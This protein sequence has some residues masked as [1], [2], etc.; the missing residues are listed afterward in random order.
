EQG[1]ALTSPYIFERRGAADRRVGKDRLQRLRCQHRGLEAERTAAIKAA[2]VTLTRRGF[3]RGG[4]ASAVPARRRF[5]AV[6]KGDS[7]QRGI[8]QRLGRADIAAGDRPGI[9]AEEIDD[10]GLAAIAGR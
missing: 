9:G 1:V 10:D 8:F 4:I 7:G 2:N 3:W 5:L 6:G